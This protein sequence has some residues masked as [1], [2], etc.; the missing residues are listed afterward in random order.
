[1]TDKISQELLQEY[2][3]AFEMYDVEGNGTIPVNQIELVLKSLGIKVH[4]A[5]LLQLQNRKV[6]EGD[7][8]VT[9]EEFLYLMQTGGTPNDYDENA[10]QDRSQKLKAAL[11]LFDPSQSG[12]ISVVDL[13]KA[14][15]D[16]MKENEIEELVKRADVGNSG[17]VECGYL[18]ELMTGC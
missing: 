5:T 11:S 7:G 13:R 9:F 4:Q 17:R 15:R 3:E 1:M 16:I 14:L 12:T 8:E 6:Q 2:A 10:A 18:A